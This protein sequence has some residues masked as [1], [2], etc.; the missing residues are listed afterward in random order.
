MLDKM[1]NN[2]YLIPIIL[3]LF[4]YVSLC[5][6]DVLPANNIFSL[7]VLVLIIYF[8]KNNILKKSEYNKDILIFS[9]FFA[10]ILIAGRILYNFRYSATDS[11]WN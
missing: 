7:L 11:F 4:T 1:M 8:Y 5:F 2:K 6:Q 10:V 3:S 9:L